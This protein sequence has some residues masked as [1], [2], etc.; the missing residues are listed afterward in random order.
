MADR[1]GHVRCVWAG[2][3]LESD[4]G[5]MYVVRRPRRSGVRSLLWTAGSIRIGVRAARAAVRR[6]EVV[7]LNGAEP[8]GWLSAW[9]VSLV[10]RRPWLMDIHA[11]YLALPV[12][13]LG[14]WRR[15]VLA[16]AVVRFARRASERRVVAQSMVDAL[17]RR[18]IPSV[19]VPPRLL[20]VWEESLERRRPLPTEP[21]PSL[22][23][24]GRLVPSKGYDIL[25][26]AFATL[27]ETVPSARLRIVG[28]G[29]EKVRLVRQ[30]DRLGLSGRVT[31]LGSR[32]VEEVRGE[33]ACADLFVISS[34]DEGL[35]RT[36][37]EAAAAE[38]P[39][40]ATSVG[41]IPAAA[42]EWASVSLV[43]ADAVSLAAGLRQAVADPPA[44]AV[45][46]A[47]R[48]HVLAVYG[49]STNLDQLADLYRRIMA[50]AGEKHR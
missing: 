41:G 21:G 19:L 27:V 29:P 18:G 8:W 34:R 13:S 33:L 43:S 20:P 17:A 15:A 32:D 45:L 11:D 44:P 31:F 9:I 49:F 40:V 10:V 12:A 5:S 4:R 47:V 37:L 14:R 50:E 16:R 23:A 1:L 28:D 3:P 48:R 2:P 38:V 35:P 36:L 25:L 30:A 24:V 42:S 6:G 46:T 7:L 26:T 39:V 22:L